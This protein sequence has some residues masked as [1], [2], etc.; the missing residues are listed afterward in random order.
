MV[1][2]SATRTAP[3]SISL[4]ARSDLPDPLLPK[5]STP[6]WPIA[7]QLAWMLALGSA[8]GMQARHGQFD[9]QARA[10]A[11]LVSGRA[12]LRIDAPARA[13]DDLAGDGQAQ[14]RITA[15]ILD[16]PLCVKALENRFQIVGRNAG[17]VIFHRHPRHHV[18]PGGADDHLA[19][20]GAER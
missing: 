20:L 14:A 9:H 10:C 13:F 18:V 16:R 19:T 17:A 8:S 1:R 6:L 4:S 12:V 3:S 7:T 11:L 2:S 5:S 15:E